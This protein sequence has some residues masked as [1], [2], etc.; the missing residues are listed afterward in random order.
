[1]YQSGQSP[2]TLEVGVWIL[3][4]REGSVGVV[5]PWQRPM[6]LSDGTAGLIA[7]ISVVS[8]ENGIIS[9]FNCREHRASLTS[10][11]PGSGSMPY[12]LS[13]SLGST[14]SGGDATGAGGSLLTAEELDDCYAGAFLW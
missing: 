7:V 9:Y 5:S 4:A 3:E 1:M 8:P 10:R 13:G 6:N 2:S 14:A 12:S 11:E